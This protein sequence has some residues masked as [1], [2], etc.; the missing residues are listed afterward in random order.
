MD[1]KE[2]VLQRVYYDARFGFGPEKDTLRRAK[3]IDGRITL[4]DVKEF[5]RRQELRHDHPPMRYN[6]WVPKS[7]RQK[8]QIDLMDWGARSN[9]RYAFVA[10]DVFTRKAAVA[11]MVRKTAKESRQAFM[12][13]VQKLGLPASIMV[14]GGSEFQGAFGQLVKK[15]FDRRVDLPQQCPFCGEGE[16]HPASHV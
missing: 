1:S 16:L 8:F 14:D 11:P 9:P 5:M 12:R 10:I 13:A 15:F 3:A 6:K 2:E 4:A 7:P